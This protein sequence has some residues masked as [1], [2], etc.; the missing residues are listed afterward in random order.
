M[1]GNYLRNV[2]QYN[3]NLWTLSIL[4][5][6]EMSGR[7]ILKDWLSPFV[8]KGSSKCGI[9]GGYLETGFIHSVS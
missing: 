7:I 3:S 4:P 9:S 2:K 6:G 5:F 8:S 1:M